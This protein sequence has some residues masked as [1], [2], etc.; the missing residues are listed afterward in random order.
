M[1]RIIDYNGYA[2]IKAHGHGRAHINS[3]VYEHIFE[4]ERTLGRPLPRSSV[5]HHVDDNKSNNSHSNLVVCE[6]DLYHRILHARARIVRRG[7]KPSIH[8]ICPTCD[9]LKLRMDFP[10]KRQASD[11]LNW[12]CKPCAAARTRRWHAKQKSLTHSPAPR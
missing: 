5:V 8:K 1:S 7:G 11:S 4:V 2:K 10:K 9:S 6:N 12:A 3:Y